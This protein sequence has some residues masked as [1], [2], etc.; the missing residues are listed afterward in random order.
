MSAIKSRILVAYYSYSGITRAAAEEIGRRVGADLFEIQPAKAYPA[1]Y[2]AVVAQ[3]KE[4]ISSGFRPALK[5]AG[6]GLDAYDIVLLGSPNWWSTIAPPVASYL[7]ASGLA[8]KKIAAFVTHGGGGLARAGADIVK[9]SPGADPLEPAAFRD[10]DVRRG[11]AALDN[12]LRRL[13]LID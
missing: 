13:K 10:S 3:A 5:Q 12:W 7:S 1:G 6:P 11:K 9:L 2:D 4:E 8:G